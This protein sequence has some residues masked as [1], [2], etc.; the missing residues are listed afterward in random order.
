[1]HSAWECWHV[2]WYK[3]QQILIASIHVTWY[4]DV[5]VIHVEINHNTIVPRQ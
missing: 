4:I 5:F 2:V 3:L 1:M